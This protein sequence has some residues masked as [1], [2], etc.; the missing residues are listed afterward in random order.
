MVSE[1]V[2]VGSQKV[3]QAVADTLFPVPD[4]SVQVVPDGMVAV[5]VCGQIGGVCYRFSRWSGRR[6]FPDTAGYT[7]CPCRSW[8]CCRF[9][10]SCRWALEGQCAR[11][12]DFSQPPRKGRGHTGTRSGSCGYCS[13]RRLSRCFPAGL[14]LP[15]R[16]GAGVR[17]R[18]CPSRPAAVLAA[19][20]AI[21]RSRFL[22][23]FP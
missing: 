5:G 21:L 11:S 14:L 7:S 1:V 17:L 10:V 8:P 9:C 6:S 13:A 2:R 12:G 19:R 20:S 15:Q 23:S 16:S 3:P 18:W 22:T 4:K